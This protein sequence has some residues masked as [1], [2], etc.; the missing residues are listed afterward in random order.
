MFNFVTLLNKSLHSVK[1]VRYTVMHNPIDMPTEQFITYSENGQGHNNN[2]PNPGRGRY[3]DR[4]EII[5]LLSL[6]IKDTRHQPSNS[7]LTGNLMF[8]LEV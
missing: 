1:E 5:T 6:H 8:C 2:C 4:I 3:R 7:R